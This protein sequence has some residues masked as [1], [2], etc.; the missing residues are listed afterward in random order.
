MQP[1]EHDAP[2]IDGSLW[3]ALECDLHDASLDRGR[4]IIAVDIIAADHVKY[5]IGA[6]AA[7]SGLGR[8]DEVL[9]FIVNGDVGSELAA[10]G[11]FFLASCRRNHTGA[12]LPGELDRGRSD[13]R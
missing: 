2:E 8:R 10:G 13:A 4:F 5:K 7:G 12:E 3:R 11:A 1:L 9:R 6:L